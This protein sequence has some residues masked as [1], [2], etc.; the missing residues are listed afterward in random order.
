ML[1]AFSWFDDKSTVASDWGALETGPGRCG[2]RA[3]AGWPDPDFRRTAAQTIA[4]TVTTTT[5][6][7]RPSCNG[8]FIV[9][10]SDS[11]LSPP[12]ARANQGGQTKGQP[13]VDVALA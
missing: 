2:G 6:A 3:G 11:G 5:V 13:R 10:L 4:A 8:L 9:T 7:L 12:V 1:I